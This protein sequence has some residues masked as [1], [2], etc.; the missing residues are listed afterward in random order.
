MGHGG[1]DREFGARLANAGLRGL[2]VRHRAIVVHLD[3]PRGYRQAETVR[4]NREIWTETER[5]GRIRAVVGLDAQ[6]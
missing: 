4:R 3:H 6:G 1:L 2:Q 5:T